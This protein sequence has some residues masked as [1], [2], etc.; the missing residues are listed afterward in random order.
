MYR[1]ST[2]R[3]R[4][5]TNVGREVGRAKQKS[6]L[7][8]MPPLPCF[9]KRLRIWRNRRPLLPAQ[10]R[11][12]RRGRL[13]NYSAAYPRAWAPARCLRSAMSKTRPAGQS[14]ACR[15]GQEETRTHRVQIL[16]VPARVVNT[17]RGNG[18]K[19]SPV[20]NISGESFRVTTTSQAASRSH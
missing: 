14:E 5:S 13:Q 19:Q 15:A 17:I 1:E 16:S 4:G 8:Q 18:D 10:G 2:V 9:I 3:Q 11:D 7:L 20:F 12:L 6:C